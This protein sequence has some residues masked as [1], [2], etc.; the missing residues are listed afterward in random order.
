[1]T[2]IPQPAITIR[3]LR[4]RQE[5]DAAVALQGQVWGYS[6]LDVDSPSMLTVASRFCGQTLGAF[7]QC[8]GQLPGELPSQLTAPESLIGFSLAFAS[9]PFGHLHSH[10]VGVHPDYQNLGIGR[11]LKLAQRED[12]LARGVNEI[13]WTFDP[14]QQRNAYFNIARLGGIARRY[15]PNLYGIT[16]SPLHGGLPTDRLMIEWHLDS[17]RVLR[18]LAGDVPNPDSKE[19]LKKDK[20]TREIRL[21]RPGLRADKAAQATL[22]EQFES[23]FSQGYVVCGFRED[24]DTHTYILEK[25]CR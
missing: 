21:P 12:A 20:D 22:R 16:T 2:G 11:K 14:L 4:T 19:R 25:P 6:N 1:M 18:V 17:E 10:R 24:G 5:L 3:P 7:K 8:P 23:H 9:L 15:I 13:Q